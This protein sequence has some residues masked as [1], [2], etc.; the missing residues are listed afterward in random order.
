MLY[1]CT[2]MATA[3]IKGLTPFSRIRIGARLNESF[4]HLTTDDASLALSLAAG[5]IREDCMR[6]TQSSSTCAVLEWTDRGSTSAST[7]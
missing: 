7:Q 4:V 6:T 5:D 2:H 1:T 3:G